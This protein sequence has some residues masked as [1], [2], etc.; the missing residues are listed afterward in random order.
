VSCERWGEG[1]NKFAQ[2]VTI[3]G[4]EYCAQT[5]HHLPALIYGFFGRKKNIKFLF[6]AT[7]EKNITRVNFLREAR[8]SSIL[9]AIDAPD[10][11]LS[12]HLLPLAKI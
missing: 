11:I 8:E 3:C 1:G 5:T 7:T 4:G 10:A 6:P 2:M 12:I 9:M